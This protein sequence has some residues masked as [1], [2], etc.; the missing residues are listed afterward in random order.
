MVMLTLSRTN[1]SY[2]KSDMMMSRCVGSI[3]LNLD[4]GA[5]QHERD[6]YAA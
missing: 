2:Q 6:I 4:T 1:S 3:D 5:T